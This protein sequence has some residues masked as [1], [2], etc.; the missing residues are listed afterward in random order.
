MHTRFLGPILLLV[1]ASHPARA[2]DV[3]FQLRTLGVQV[4]QS[5]VSK[6]TDSVPLEIKDRVWAAPAVGGDVLPAQEFAGD[7]TT[8]WSLAVLAFNEEAFHISRDNRYPMPRPIVE[9]THWIEKSLLP[10]TQQMFSA[11]ESQQAVFSQVL[12]EKLNSHDHSKPSPL[13]LL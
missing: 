2:A 3:Q 4:D 5:S 10:L 6:S 13:D 8:D 11:R 7:K 1:F 9:S 12:C